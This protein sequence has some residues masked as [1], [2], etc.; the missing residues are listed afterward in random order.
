MGA[1][2]KTTLELSDA[3]LE[4][5]KGFASEHGLTLR[6]IVEHALRGYLAGAAA[7]GGR[8]VVPYRVEPWRGALRHAHADKTA[9]ELVHETLEERWR[10]RD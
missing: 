10:D 5:A 7:T 2:M 4:Q 1:H 3:I 8:P 9:T 6:A